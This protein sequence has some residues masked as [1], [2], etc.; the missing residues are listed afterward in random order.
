MCSIIIISILICML[1]IQLSVC[2]FAIVVAEFSLRRLQLS[3]DPIQWGDWWTKGSVSKWKK[4]W[5]KRRANSKDM[6][7][8]VKWNSKQEKFEFWS[9]HRNQSTTTDEKKSKC[10]IE[11]DLRHIFHVRIDSH[12]HT[13]LLENVFLHLLPITLNPFAKDVLKIDIY[14]PLCLTEETV[15]SRFIHN[16]KSF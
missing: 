7:N 1:T 16:Q 9:P 11:M 13:A 6:K 12:A 4:G 2:L 15:I 5:R 14:I 10:C 3:A 8:K